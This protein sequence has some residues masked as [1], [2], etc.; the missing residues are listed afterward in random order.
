MIILDENAC[1]AKGSQRSVFL[2]PEDNTKCIKI[3]LLKD[4]Q[5]VK[6]CSKR[7]YKKL[8][9]AHYFSENLKEIKF[10]N[11]L[12]RKN[13]EIYNCL[14]RYYGEIETN[15]GKG[16]LVDYIENA[17]SLKEYITEYGISQDLLEAMK[18][19][20]NTL[21]KNLIYIRDQHTENY[22]IQKQDNKLK[23]FL[24]D[25]LGNPTFIKI[26]NEIPFIK[27]HAIINKINVLMKNLKKDF[28]QYS[29]YFKLEN[30][31]EK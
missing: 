20:L 14:P 18:Y 15:I 26:F 6:Q 25:G 17:T 19:T 2:S 28:P 3:T 24:I 22:V 27:R 23:M 9:P 31:I 21:Y 1:I 10:Y 13:E 11:S 7:W 12:K 4:L 29:D 16:M 30:F 5:K 8:R